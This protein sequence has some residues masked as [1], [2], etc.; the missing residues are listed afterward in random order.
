MAISSVSGSF[1]PQALGLLGGRPAGA[2]PPAQAQAQVQPPQSQTLAA[3]EAQP[4][5]PS[6]T[7]GGAQAEPS[8]TVGGGQALA[9][10][11]S[12]AV[13]SLLDITV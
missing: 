3:S 7:L 11:G 13:G 10:G 6:P 2:E 8:Q 1:G 5:P 4:A 12:Q 9:T